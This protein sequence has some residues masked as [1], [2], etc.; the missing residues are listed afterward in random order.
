MC[1]LQLKCQGVSKKLMP[2]VVL[3]QLL[4]ASLS[5]QSCKL[6]PLKML[7][8]FSLREVLFLICCSHLAERKFKHLNQCRQ[9]NTANACKCLKHLKGHEF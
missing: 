7:K 5:V 4:L 9:Q 1:C 8:S 2:F 6:G 3:G